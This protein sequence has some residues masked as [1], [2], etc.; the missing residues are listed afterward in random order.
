MEEMEFHQP[1]LRRDTQVPPGCTSALVHQLYPG[2]SQ[3]ECS[4]PG[5]PAQLSSTRSPTRHP[6]SGPLP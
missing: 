6:P 3:W 2:P 5:C 4:Q 1:R